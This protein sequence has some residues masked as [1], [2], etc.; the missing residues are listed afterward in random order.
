MSLLSR[1]SKPSKAL[2]KLTY[3]VRLPQTEYS[4]K[5]SSLQFF[6]LENGLT[7]ITEAFSF[8]SN[9]HFGLLYPAGAKNE[10]KNCPGTLQALQNT[11]L[12]P[13]EPLLYTKL[14]LMGCSL[15]M[16]FDEEFTFY[17]GSCLPQHFEECAQILE[18]IRKHEKREE[19]GEIVKERHKALWEIKEEETILSVNSQILKENLWNGP[20][21]RGIQGK[22]ERIPSVQEIN[23]FVKNNLSGNT[24]I[25]FISGVEN[26]EETANICKKIFKE[27]IV[28]TSEAKQ[29]LKN[30]FLQK[31]V[32]ISCANELS[33]VNVTFEAGSIKDKHFKT[34]ELL[35]YVYGDSQQSSYQSKALARVNTSNIIKSAKAENLSF[36]D[37]GAFVFTYSLYN[38]YLNSFSDI[39]LKDLNDLGK[40]TEEELERAKKNLVFD[41]V[42]KLEQRDTRVESNLKEFAIFN[43][44]KKKEE[45]ISE[46]LSITLKDIAEVLLQMHKGK[47]NLCYL[48]NKPNADP[49]LSRLFSKLTE[50]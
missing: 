41:L 16:A 11:F 7:L 42:Y 26:H 14:Q 10:D 9:L 1:F 3:S 37:V 45:H 39:F 22:K 35:K 36:T 24:P 4:A 38:S 2:P 43:A 47:K 40:I 29:Q 15:A 25:L 5:P 12:G 23:Q 33:I 8:P 48:S 21:G 44:I 13:E 19:E 27:L 6:Q 30:E 50:N 46:I 34:F 32:Q 18:N 17:S 49:N 20:I 28:S 31:E